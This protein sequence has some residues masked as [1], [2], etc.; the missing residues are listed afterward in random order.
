[1]VWVGSKPG[2]SQQQYLREWSDKNPDSAVNL[3]VD[4]KQFGAYAANK[5]VR[6][7]VNALFPDAKQYQQEKLFRG[8]FSQLKTTL[9]QP[10]T[11]LNRAAQ[12]QAL[13]EL[14]KELGAEDNRALSQALL[15][16]G[17]KVTPQNAE[18]VLQ[19]FQ[20]RTQGNDEKFLQA[21]RLILDQTV[22]AW[23]RCAGDCPRDTDALQALREQFADRGNIHIRDLSDPSDIQLKNRDA[24]Q[25]EIIGRNG[26][27][28]A[29]SDIARYEILHTYGGVYADIDLECTQPLSG[30]LNAHPDLMLVGLAEGKREASGSSTP[31]FA[32]ALL[33]SHPGSRMLADFIDKI[34][35]DYQGM[36]GNQFAGDRYFSRPNKST[37]EGT[38]PNALRGQVGTV[39]HQGEPERMR[40][41]PQSLAE[42]IWD[43]SQ[44]QNQDF[45]AAMESHFKF[46]DGYV[47]FETEEQQ[48]SA[49]KDMA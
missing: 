46:P 16:D 40:N 48:Q 35:N 8:L 41:D 27:Y 28:P 7:Q 49:T 37:I 12:K 22:K 25:H 44:P 14:N 6:E 33:A 20:Q 2:A 32:N 1:M 42:R 23:D 45:W 47:N 43:R 3:W 29:A 30:A 39:I 13:G 5:E 18:K 15:P 9:R 10:D 24:Y 36:R 4:S 17:G 38:G 26:A 11:A 19:A 21:D 34:G 31:Y